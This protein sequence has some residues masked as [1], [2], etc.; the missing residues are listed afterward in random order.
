MGG[1]SFP[2]VLARSTHRDES[3]LAV[4]GEVDLATVTPFRD[5]MMSILAEPGLRRLVVDMAE[6]TFL[7]AR[8][9]AALV[10]AWQ[11]AEASDVRFMVVNCRGAVRRVL[12][13]T[14]VSKALGIHEADRSVAGKVA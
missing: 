4:R 7:D 6:V 12:E 10:A 1:R 3:V 14:G 9:V 11:A 5:L 8:G 13:I 2:L